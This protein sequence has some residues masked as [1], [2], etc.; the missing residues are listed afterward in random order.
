MNFRYNFKTQPM[1]EIINKLGF[2]KFKTFCSAK[3]DAKA[4]R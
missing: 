3:D 4:I 2:I 1:K